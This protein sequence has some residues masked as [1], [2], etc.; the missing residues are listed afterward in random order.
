MIVENQGMT[1]KI[2][3][4]EVHEAIGGTNFVNAIGAHKIP[5]QASFFY[6]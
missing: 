1:N 4:E 2:C 5:V 3:E 6:F